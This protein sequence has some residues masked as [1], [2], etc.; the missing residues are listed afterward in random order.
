MLSIAVGFGIA[1]QRLSKSSATATEASEVTM[2]IFGS[3]GETGG[4]ANTME[5]NV[6]TNTIEKTRITE[7]VT[8]HLV[9]YPDSYINITSGTLIIHIKNEGTVATVVYMIEVIGVG[10]ITGNFAWGLT[11]TMG[12]RASE[13]IINP[14]AEGY[15]LAPIDDHR[16]VPGTNY[17]VKIYTRAHNIYIF[18]IKALE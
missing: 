6:A 15:I 16:L 1:W 3:M 5:T 14:R 10:K 8:E 2:I 13:V 11:P 4:G 17:Q 7:I 9:I 12:T 18:D